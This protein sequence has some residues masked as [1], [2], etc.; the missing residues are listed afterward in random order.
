MSNTNTPLAPKSA[1]CQH[2][3][4]RGH[5]C[6][7]LVSPGNDGLCPH[8][9]ARLL[10]ERRKNDE[11]LAAELLSP[12]DD[13]TTPVSV[14][15][16]LGNLLRQLVYKRIERPDALAQAYICQ[17]I[18]N[19]FPA[20]QRE[21]ASEEK[22]SASQFLIDAMTRVQSAVAPPT[23]SPSDSSGGNIPSHLDSCGSSQGFTSPPSE[24]LV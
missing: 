17:L 7:M 14:N 1:Q 12:I 21:F 4:S 22:G 13:F 20:I 2:V 11:I 10:A 15:L 9:Y 24:V 18:L 5:R 19:T 8:H 3:N 16:F 6:R 23:R